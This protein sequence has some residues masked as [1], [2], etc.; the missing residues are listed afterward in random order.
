MKKVICVG[1]ATKDTF[2]GVAIDDKV[3]GKIC[4]EAGAKI[5]TKSFRE[6]VGGG[7]VNVGT[8]LTKLGYRT[9]IFARTDKGISGKWIIKQIGKVK[10]KKNY[11]QQNGGMPSQTSV[12]ISDCIENDH[13]ILRSGDA[14][15]KFN[16][17][18]A[19]KKFKEG[20]DWIYISSQK[21]NNLENLDILI[22]FANEKKAKLTFN[23]SSYQ[24]NNNPEKLLAKLNTIEVL[25]LNLNEA[26]KLLGRNITEYK[27]NETGEVA[28][29]KVNSL[30]KKLLE[31]QAKV[32][33][34]TD[35]ANGAW[36]GSL[37]NSEIMI[38]YLPAILKKGVADTTGAGDAFA[39][40]FLA[41]YIKD[42]SELK[43]IY[44]TKL[45]R[46]LAGGLVNSAGVISEIGA[47]NGLSKPSALKRGIEKLLRDKFIT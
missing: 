6:E 9:F 31:F 44:T 13:T 39:S 7:A 28:D 36:V 19:C 29:D 24:I 21:K 40:G 14:V 22:N 5:Y 3:K 17:L 12:I 8:G 32:V 10:L 11:M 26:T 1:S 47:T 18:K 34:I 27:N 16:L 41:T 25:F 46:A 23:P 45:Q 33:V 20:A 38:Y 2:L 42:E 30:L 43:M 35:G 15:E 4:L 37:V